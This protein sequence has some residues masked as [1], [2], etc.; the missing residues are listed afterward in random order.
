MASSIPRYQ[1]E[2]L[3]A[4]DALRI[5][6]LKPASN[7]D[8]PLECEIIQYR[9]SEMFADPDN[10]KQYEAISYCWGDDIAFNHYLFCNNRMDKVAI[11]KSVDS[12]LRHFREVY[13]V[14]YYW[15]DAVCLNQA[16][17]VEK[18]AQIPLMGDVYR[19][20]K[21]VRIWLG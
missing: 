21:K 12:M 19:Q 20:A 6:A 2:P 4:P 8:D 17:G 5:I 7:F 18:G 3:C 10:K 14:Q 15:V 9:R 11:T 16:D 13:S 1:Y